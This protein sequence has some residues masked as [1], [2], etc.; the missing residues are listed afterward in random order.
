MYTSLVLLAMLGPGATPSASEAPKWQESYG[1]A[2][3]EAKRQGKPV[4]VFVGR[5]KFGWR[6]VSRTADLSA[7]ALKRLESRYVCVY[8]DA[9]TTSGA[10]LAE[11]F[12]MT[13]GLI[14]STKEGGEQA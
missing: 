2:L 10:Q 3:Q 14:L 12:R 6:L 11:A 4:A 9:A 7:T 8:V 5:G 1:A 13:R